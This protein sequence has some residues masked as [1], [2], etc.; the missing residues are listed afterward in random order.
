MIELYF[1]LY[2]IP[3]IMTRLARERNRSALGWTLMAI[4]AWL[5]S[6][7]LVGVIFGLIHVIGEEV[8]GWPQQPLGF[9]PLVYIVSLV[10]A[11]MSF[12]V[13]SRILTNKPREE[14]LPSPP[15]PPDFQSSEFQKLD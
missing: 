3:K 2:R 4:G 6:E 7:V 14:I 13:V 8:W 9:N 12:S 11:L 1:L 10:A 5:G 15:P